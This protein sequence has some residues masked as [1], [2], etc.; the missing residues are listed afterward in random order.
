MSEYVKLADYVGLN[1]DA[2]QLKV[3]DS[4]IEDAIKDDLDATVEE[5]EVTEGVVE[6]G[7]VVNIDYSGEMDGKVAD[8]TVAEGYDLEIGSGSFIPGFE[9]GLIGKKIGS[10]CVLNIKF[11]DD[12]GKADYAGKPIA[13]TVKIN[14]AKKKLTPKLSLKWVKKHTKFDTIKA[15]KEQVKN[16]LYEENMR[17]VGAGLLTSITKKSEIIKYPKKEL[18]ELTQTAIDYYKETAETN[19][20]SYNDYVTG[21]MGMD[22]ESFE[23]QLQEQAKTEIAQEIV[24]YAIAKKEGIEAQDKDVSRYVDD[25]MAANGLTKKQFEKQVGMSRA[26]YIKTYKK[27]IIVAITVQNVQQLLVDK[28]KKN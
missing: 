24:A 22:I 19:G 13:F 1:Y 21:Q 23:A 4:D 25:L 15:Y 12:Y 6:N 10:T 18:D 9:S 7:D 3:V 20:M 16:D 8:G 27:D 11:P 14:S 2:E 28:G 26:K 5:Q 17:S